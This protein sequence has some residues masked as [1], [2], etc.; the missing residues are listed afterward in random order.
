MYKGL[1]LP[2]RGN[3]N[4][5]RPAGSHAFVFVQ[6]FAWRVRVKLPARARTGHHLK[7]K[8]LHVDSVSSKLVMGV[9]EKEKQEERTSRKRKD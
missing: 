6:D 2:Q 5:E 3:K 1:I 9:V 4:D 7:L 8:I